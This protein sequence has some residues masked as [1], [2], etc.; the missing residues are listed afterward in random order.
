MN[1]KSLTIFNLIIV[2]ICVGLFFWFIFS[3]Q[4]VEIIPEDQ[5]EILQYEKKTYEYKEIEFDYP[6]DWELKN[7]KD[8]NVRDA[9]TEEL[10][11]ASSFDFYRDKSKF[12]TLENLV[13]IF[14]L[15]ELESNK[16]VEE[17]KTFEKNNMQFKAKYLV[18]T[19]TLST[20]ETVYM[21]YVIAENVEQ[22][23]QGFM[24]TAYPK[25]DEELKYFNDIFKSIR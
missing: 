14:G 25:D 20:G 22:W 15:E 8:Y 23:D 7:Y 13:T 1:K 19:K 4:L 21:V 11:P 10:I 16:V 24:I 2:A 3:F 12:A 17:N 6:L 5:I 9:E 18:Y